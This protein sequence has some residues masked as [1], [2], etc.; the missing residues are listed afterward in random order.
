MNL[1]CIWII[2]LQQRKINYG[3]YKWSWWLNAETAFSYFNIGMFILVL[4]NVYTIGQEVIYMRW[5]A[6]PSYSSRPAPSMIVVSKYYFNY[7]HLTLY[8]IYF[9]TSPFPLFSFKPRKL[10]L[11]TSLS[12]QELSVASSSSFRVFFKLPWCSS[13]LKPQDHPFNK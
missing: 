2:L 12:P 8:P 1:K 3:K 5:F 13:L 4:V 11:N 7:F 10:K 6:I 9:P